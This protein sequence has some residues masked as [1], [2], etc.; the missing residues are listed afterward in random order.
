[1]EVTA[2]KKAPGPVERKW[3]GRM[4]RSFFRFH[5]SSARPAPLTLL[6]WTAVRFE[7]NSG[8][9]VAGRWFHQAH[10]Q[11][12]VVL[13]HPDRRSGQQWFLTQGWIEFLLDHGFEVLTFDFAGYGDTRGGSTYL[14]EDAIAACR[15]AK[16]RAD[17][18]P[19]HLV[20]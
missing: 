4:V 13:A 16:E 1:M 11:G 8:A 3:V 12:V 6:P 9:D 19:V 20:G 17:G 5:R 18:R 7:G 14:L 2:S 10:A 15:F